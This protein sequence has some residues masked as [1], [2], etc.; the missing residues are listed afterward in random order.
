MPAEIIEDRTNSI[1][2][3]EVLVIPVPET[4]RKTR[5]CAWRSID[6]SIYEQDPDCVFIS[7]ESSQ[8]NGPTY[9]P[10]WD[11]GDERA[12]RRCLCKNWADIIDFIL[13]HEPLCVAEETSRDNMLAVQNTPI[14]DFLR[15]FRQR[16]F[17]TFYG[18][19]KDGDIVLTREHREMATGES[20]C[21]FQKI[22]HTNFT[23]FNSQYV[24]NT[25]YSSFPEQS[26][27]GVYLLSPRSVGF[28]RNLGFT[29]HKITELLVL[30]SQIQSARDAG[31]D[32]DALKEIVKNAENRFL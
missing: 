3:Y 26:G 7:I 21:L 25:S 11:V 30:Q 10:G 5:I 14:E 22:A 28:L 29:A 31:S 23:P 6:F 8:D 16:R 2:P 17:N 32:L 1:G 15:A 13:A 27:R 19:P 24:R 9:S 20:I 4:T 12:I 18:I